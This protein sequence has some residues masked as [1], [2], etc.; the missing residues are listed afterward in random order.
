M[1]DNGEYPHNPDCQCEWCDAGR[2]LSP[3]A[4]TLPWPEQLESRDFERS[5]FFKLDPKYKEIFF[6]WLATKMVLPAS[7]G[8]IAMREVDGKSVQLSTLHE[9]LE[10]KLLEF[11]REFVNETNIQKGLL[12]RHFP[13]A[14]CGVKELLRLSQEK[15][16][17]IVTYRDYFNMYYL[18]N[19][20][21]PREHEY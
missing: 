14:V 2:C 18:G 12:F 13:V 4:D 21:A 1:S 15:F 7:P 17:R 5:K 19:P 6:A 9:A 11:F 10:E 20:V 8:L 16:E 3:I